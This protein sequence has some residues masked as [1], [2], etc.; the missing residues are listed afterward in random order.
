MK[1]LIISLL[2]LFVFK[3]HGQVLDSL[4]FQLKQIPND[5]ERVNRIY[6]AGFEKRNTQ[7]ELSY[8]Y[9]K[10]CEI[11]A[12]KTNS[13]KHLAKSYSLSGILYYKKGEY[14]KALHYHKM[15][16][17]LNRSVG[18]E[19]G[20]AIN[21]TNLGNIYNEVGYYALAESSYLKA[22]KAYNAIGD[23]IQIIK[24]LNNLGV[25]KFSLKEY[26]SALKQFEEALVIAEQLNNPE[27]KALCNNNIGGVLTTQNKLDS[28][29]LY[30][31]E[32]LKLLDITGNEKEMADSYINLANIYIKKANL[33]DAQLNIALADSICHKYEYS[34]AKIELYQTYS[35]LYEAQQNYKEANYWLKKHYH[36]KDSLL[37]LDKEMPAIRLQDD[38]TVLLSKEI[39]PVFKNE[40][41][42]VFLGVLLIG[43]PL[44]LMRH[45]R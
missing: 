45:K 43:I 14:T 34:E 36:L 7:P 1:A 21:Q 5:T 4:L 39:K 6:K 19:Y 15:S 20:I 32:G 12:K 25:L 2:L 16:L 22:L 11:E 23:N 17:A 3:S 29:L 41:I 18:Y 13:P 24:C 28:A 8:Q 42:L 44:L 35:S 37:Q 9:A 10:E 30:L 26:E 33:A 38:D 27:L 40:W 31:E